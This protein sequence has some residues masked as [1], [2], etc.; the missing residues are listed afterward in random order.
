M[1]PYYT[2]DKLIEFIDEPQKAKFAKLYFENESI[3]K[4][5]VGST[6]NHQAWEGGYLDHVQD[7]MNIAVQFYRC[8]NNLRSLPFTLSDTL[9]TVF[10]HDLEKPWKYELG[11]DNQYRHRAG[12]Q[13]KTEHQAFRIKK[14]AEYGITLTKP[15]INGI[16]YAEGEINDYT[17]T[18]RVM[19]PLAAFTHLC[20]VT[21]ARIWFDYPRAQND[22]WR[23]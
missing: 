18:R 2:V 5:T 10:A 12:M 9:I 13:T 17:N 16:Q 4:K 11:A 6:H 3:F 7:A 23:T 19:E 8:M 21:S 14:L 22:G 1:A 20:D 15:Q